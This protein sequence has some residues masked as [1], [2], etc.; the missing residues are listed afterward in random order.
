MVISVKAKLLSS[1]SRAALLAAAAVAVVPCAALIA[2][3]A[4]ADCNASGS[5]LECFGTITSEISYTFPRSGGTLLVH[6]VDGVLTPTPGQNAISVGIDQGGPGNLTVDISTITIVLNS[7]GVAIGLSNVGDRDE[8][9]G[10]ITALLVNPVTITTVGDNGYAVLAESYGGRGE[11]GGSV[12]IGHA[13]SGHAG[14]PG[15]DISIISGAAATTHGSGAIALFGRSVAGHGGNGGHSDTFGDGGDGGQGG[16]N[17]SVTVA[18][19]N[20]GQIVTYGQSAS[21]AVGQNLGGRGGDAGHGGLIGGGGDGGYAGHSGAVA[22]NNTGI[23]TTYGDKAV[24]LFSHSVGGFGGAGGNEVGFVGYG[25]DA[26]SGGN[27]GEVTI[28]NGGE[29]S[30]GGDHAHAI[31]AQ[32]VG[33]GGGAGGASYGIVGLGGFGGIGGNGGTVNVTSVG[34]LSTKGVQSF[35][36]FAQSVGGSGGDG[37][38]SGGLVSVGGDAAQGGSASDVLVDSTGVITTVGS[39]AYG[40]M[41]Q[42]VGGGGGHGGSSGGVVSIGGAGGPGGDGAD[43]TALNR[44]NSSVATQ[45]DSAAAIFAQSVG[46]GG[47][48][49]GSTVAVGLAMSIAI[50]GAG[51]GGG[52]GQTVTV[53]DCSPQ[54]QTG[55]ASPGNNTIS[56]SGDNSAGIHAQSVGGGG[57]HGGY[58]ISA[59]AGPDFSFSVA[60]GGKGGVGGSA[61]DVHAESGSVITTS[62]SFASGAVAESIGGGGGSGGFAIAGSMSAGPS[63]SLSLGGGGAGGGDGGAAT[64][65][66]YNTVATSGD[67]SHGLFAQSVGGGGGNGGFA[68]S[69]AVA[70]GVAAAFAIGGSAGAGGHGG[71]VQVSADKAIE[72]QGDISHG[73]FAQ[74]VGGGGGHGGFAIGGAVSTEG[75]GASFALGGRGGSG[76]TGDGVTV[77]SQDAVSTAG[78]GS[79]GVFAQSVGGGGG[80]GGFAGSFAVSLD[81]GAELS[82]G[83]GGEGGNG[84]TA[85]DANVF[86]YGFVST[87]GDDANAVMAQSIGGGGGHG[88][89]S[90]SA[91]IGNESAANVSVSVGGK[92]GEGGHAAAAK[93]TATGGASTSGHRSH[94]V[95]AQSIGGGG[96]SGGLSVSGAFSTTP[97]SNNLALSVGG[98]G[99]SGGDGGAVA[100]LAGGAISTASDHSFGVFGQSVGGGGGDGGL[101]I[102]GS[103]AK[104]ESRSLDFSIGGKGG[105]AGDGSTVDLSVTDSVVTTGDWSH[106]IFGQSIGGGGGNGGMAADL[107]VSKGGQETQVGIAVGGSGGAGGKAGAV[108]ISADGGAITAGDSAVAVFA[109]SI[110]G[111]GGNGGSSFIFSF[112]R[113]ASDPGRALNAGITIGGAGGAA[114]NAGDVIVTTAGQIQTTGVSAHGI[115]AQSIGGGG[116]NGGS[117]RDMIFNN[118]GTPEPGEDPDAYSLQIDVGGSGGASGDGKS[119]AVTNQASITTNGA[120]AH[121]IMAQSIGGGGGNGGNGGHGKPLP[122]TPGE[123][124]KPTS[125]TFSVGGSGGAAGNGDDVTIVNGIA[126]TP[127]SIVTQGDGSS[128]I[129]AQSIGGGGGVGGYGVTGK[130]TSFGLGGAGGAAGNGGAIDVQSFSLLQT[131]GVSAHAVLLQ[132]IG[133]GGGIA[134]AILGGLTKTGLGVEFGRDGGGAGHGGTVTFSNV[135]EIQTSADASIGIFAQSIGGGGGLGGSVDSETAFA[136]STGGNG[137]AAAVAITQTGNL[138][139]SG[140][141]SVGIFAQSSAGNDSGPVTVN[142]SGELRTFGTA[143]GIQAESSSGTAAGAVDVTVSGAVSTAGQDSTAISGSSTGKQGAGPVTVT[144]VL[145]S[146]FTWGLRSIGIEAASS[147]TEGQA[148]TVTV[149]AGAVGT[150]GDDAV[151]I[152]A[153]SSGITSSKVAVTASGAIATAGDRAH[154]IVATSAGSGGDIDIDVDAALS[155]RGFDAD[156]IQAIADAGSSITITIDEHVSGGAGDAAAVRVTGG[157]ANAVSVSGRLDALSG[158]ATIAGSGDETINNS[159]LIAGNID[160]GTG[161]NSFLNTSTG[162]FNSSSSVLLNGGLLTNAGALSPG[163]IGEVQTTR[164]D[165]AFTQQNSGTL[166]YDV[167]FSTAASDQLLM[168]GAAELDGKLVVGLHALDND[169]PITVLSA[170][171]GITL[172]GITVDDTATATYSLAV[173]GNDL[174]LG[175]KLNYDVAGLTGNSKRLAEHLNAVYA[176]GDDENMSAVLVD[177]ASIQDVAAYEQALAGINPEAHIANLSAVIGAAGRFSQK[178]MSCRVAEGAYAPIAEDE[179]IWAHFERRFTDQEASESLVGYD[180]IASEIAAGTQIAI[181]SNWRA[182]VAVGYSQTSLRGGDN[183]HS[184]GGVFSLG[185]S[186]KYVDGPLLLGASVSGGWGDF[187]TNRSVTVPAPDSISGSLETSYVSAMLRSAYL[188]EAGNI[189][190]K[191][192]VD[193][194]VTHLKIDDLRE[195]GANPLSVSST[196][197]SE[198]IYTVRPAVEFGASLAMGSGF[199]VRP[200]LEVSGNFHFGSDMTLPLSFASDPSNVAPLDIS[201][202]MPDQTLGLAAGLDLLNIDN[203][204]VSLRYDAQIAD[205][206]LEQTGR[207][208]MSIG[209]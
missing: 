114:G 125:A 198:N 45:G 52:D 19:T 63:G 109:Q 21:G 34:Q 204:S 56:T 152:S 81:D 174:K 77:T 74:S 26:G 54:G 128:A 182:G 10:T 165:G 137:T 42:A 143:A 32:S 29:I 35:A 159:G 93:L 9:G 90:F 139:T 201:G 78:D 206:F 23:I 116:G 36:I 70:D 73:I 43:V 40:I 88:G 79:R 12:F 2:T 44:E 130:L 124:K 82:V 111:G 18:L 53:L 153:T 178:L 197:S 181:D 117:V 160:L 155:A 3:P 191:P 99:N 162:A 38:D 176:S 187:D 157:G 28:G 25:G 69:G 193:V 20:T 172:N 104:N 138:S 108:T 37:G 192:L 119:V 121:G 4:R 6:D 207:I 65:V 105:S 118:G 57:G 177:L 154:G 208:K 22:L 102:S 195:T 175:L 48:T 190:V 188:F 169:T 129:F 140:T 202:A 64:L 123:V 132:S 27:G 46:G 163:G 180:S 41:A 158:W 75:A 166:Y 179:C 148:G 14:Q 68:I 146:I 98:D 205:D 97:Q 185:G 142:Y 87:A 17:S 161:N 186:A 31:Y 24:G 5:V 136:G 107:E 134:G 100:L 120:D 30:T 84:Q 8:P 127:V 11:N 72:T 196:G 49:G 1:A 149:S 110:G 168:T 112:I 141:G 50:G 96:G 47:G 33:G 58:A 170:D 189:Y 91:A 194:S 95:V 86:Q 103:F 66:V 59:S 200:Y 167:N 76:G 106:A 7:P 67:H 133:G 135:G 126:G 71:T 173:D 60:L 113:N 55:C 15:G 203:V 150:Q 147:S 209:F 144:S 83:I 80:A 151:A 164:I 131:Y 183:Y 122:P 171:G 61:G 85:G 156:A 62:G 13:H 115:H 199:V 145:S 16:D 92:G 89:F 39:G 184:D 51:G 101:A 94:A